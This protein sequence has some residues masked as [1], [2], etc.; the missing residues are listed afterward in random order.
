M[1]RPPFSYSSLTSYLAFTLTVAHKHLESGATNLLPLPVSWAECRSRGWDFLD[2]LLVTGDAYIDHP[3]FGVALIGRLL[4]HHGYRVAILAQP[5]YD[6]SRD[7]L[8]FPAPRLF[9][10]ITGGNLDSIVANYTGNGK[11]RE[12]D[13]YSPKG[14]PWRSSDHNKNNRYRP[15]RA[16]LIYANLARS[17]FKDTPIIL[18]GVEA[19]LR[20]FVHYDYK[21]NKLRASLLA[22]AKADLLIY[23]MAEQAVLSTAEKCKNGEPLN[24]IPGTC[25]RLTDSQLQERYPHYCAE[26]SNQ[27]FLILPSFADIHSNKELFLKAELAIDIHSRATSN[28]VIL[29]RQQHHWVVQH[30]ASP[31]LTIEALD[32]LYEFPYT[33]KPH[34]STPDVPAYAMI[35]DSVTIVRGCSGNC[36]FCAI[37][38]HQGAAIQSRSN[39]SIL[40][41]CTLLARQDDF[42]GTI[43]DLGGPTANLFATSCAIGTCAKKDCLYPTLCKHLRIDEQR[44]IN[45]LKNVSAI[46]SVRHVF[47]SSGLRMELLLNTPSLLE[48]IITHHTPGAMKIAPEHTSDEVLTLM[49]KESHSLLKRFVEKCRK[50]SSGKRGKTLQLVPYVISAHPGC[51]E[52]HAKQLAE[53]MAA[54]KLRISKFQDFTPTPGTISTA[55]Y[56]AGQDRDGKKIFVPRNNEERMRQRRIIEERFLNRGRQEEKSVHIKVGKNQ[57]IQK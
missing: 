42:Q 16:S 14:N 25:E 48:K 31:T 4:E 30:Q 33:R 53:D 46:D 35:K 29:Q 9:C 52:R 6:S 40:R 10:G 44:F 47:I 54:L 21:Q 7:F 2:I 15:D 36:S 27:D 43:S 26:D 28:K 55:M 23:G 41:E 32:S 19:S 20:R 22:D 56:V 34:P 5:R 39:D 51:T 17:A 49:H 37:T 11:V 18:G 50:I 38:R 8:D 24:A 1:F 45:L 12:T 13:A 57:K 3:S